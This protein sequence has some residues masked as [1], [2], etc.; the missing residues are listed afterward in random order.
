MK[1]ILGHGIINAKVPCLS[2]TP[3][4]TNVEKII[5]VF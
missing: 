5:I 3:S 2:S 4:L 1:S